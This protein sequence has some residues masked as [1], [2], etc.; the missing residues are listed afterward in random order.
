M[1]ERI[2]AGHAKARAV[3]TL[4][5][6]TPG[7]TITGRL[8]SIGGRRRRAGRAVVRLPSGRHVTRDVDQLE[9][10]TDQAPRCVP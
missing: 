1:A 10:V 7:T 6:H 8:V 5:G 4:P 9:L 2:N 3:V